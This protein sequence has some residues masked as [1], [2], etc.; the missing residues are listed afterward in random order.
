MEQIRAPL[1]KT[2]Q[3]SDQLESS[4]QYFRLN[5]MV[6]FFNQ[7]ILC[8]EV[9]NNTLSGCFT[10]SSVNHKPTP[11]II[12]SGRT[13][14]CS[15]SSEPP[16]PPLCREKHIPLSRVLVTIGD[17]KNTPF[18]RAFSRNL[19][20]T[21]PPKYSPF[22]KE[23]NTLAPLIIICVQ[24][25]RGIV[26]HERRSSGRHNERLPYVMRYERLFYY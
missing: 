12:E 18:P 10:K 13:Y 1:Q 6:F 16:P 19:P 21:T 24:V 26:S 23:W 25:G 9:Q 15:P 17:Y 8:I 4:F 22:P 7:R 5:V 3:K 2:K 14:A 11:T 20:E